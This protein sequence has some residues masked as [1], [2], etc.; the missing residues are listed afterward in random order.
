VPGT[1]SGEG[2]IAD[3]VV[4]DEDDVVVDDVVGAFGSEFVG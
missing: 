3:D 2:G 4:V 1:T